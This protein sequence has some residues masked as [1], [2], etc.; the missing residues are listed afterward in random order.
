M[1]SKSGICVIYRYVFRELSDIVWVAKCHRSGSWCPK[2]E[3]EE[4]YPVIHGVY[5]RI[6]GASRIS[7]SNAS[8]LYQRENRYLWGRV[9][10]LDCALMAS[11]ADSAASLCIRSSNWASGCTGRITKQ[12]NS[13][14]LEFPHLNSFAQ[15][16]NESM[17][18][19][20]EFL[21]EAREVEMAETLS[22]SKEMHISFFGWYPRQPCMPGEWYCH[23]FPVANRAHLRIG[24]CRARDLRRRA[25][26]SFML[27]KLSSALGIGIPG[28]GA[29]A[30]APASILLFLAGN[31]S[32]I[33]KLHKAQEPLMGSSSSSLNKAAASRGRPGAEKPS[34]PRICLPPSRGSASPTMRKYTA[35]ELCSP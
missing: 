15:I 1:H 13:V 21:S 16:Q 8:P 23:A 12:T 6:S 4:L 29:A 25:Q 22:Y 27:P 7:G 32:E 5:I 24:P 10:S 35:T 2:L 19:V 17:Q 18:L 33:G 3:L 31:P 20:V 30:F 14:Q 11:I 28:A 26:T 9:G 34:G